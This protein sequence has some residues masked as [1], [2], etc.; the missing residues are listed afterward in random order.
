MEV[1]KGQCPRKSKP[2]VTLTRQGQIYISRALFRMLGW[3]PFG[4]C[5]IVIGDGRTSLIFRQVQ[6][7]APGTRSIGSLARGGFIICCRGVFRY[8]GRMDLLQRKGPMKWDRPRQDELS[9]SLSLDG[10]AT[11]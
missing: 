5:Q 1:Y 6:K 11:P 4:I 2:R 9:V 3:K 10:D 8:I 7:G